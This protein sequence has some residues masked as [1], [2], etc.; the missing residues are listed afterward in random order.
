[1]ALY[2]NLKSVIFQ[3]TKSKTDVHDQIFYKKLKIPSAQLFVNG[4]LDVIRPYT[5]CLKKRN[6]NF[7]DIN[8]SIE[9]SDSIGLFKKV[10]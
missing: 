7:T 3:Q 8:W 9:L 10:I 1:M 5:I 4:I 2:L 6:T